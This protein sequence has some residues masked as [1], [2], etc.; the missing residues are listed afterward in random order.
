[1]KRREFTKLLAGSCSL[2]LLGAGPTLTSAAQAAPAPTELKALSRTIEVNGRAAKVFGLMQADGTHGLRLKSEDSFN[3]ALTN[4]TGEDT[5][6]H[7]HGLTPPW[8]ADGA[9]C[10]A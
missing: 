6:V 10:D 7:W 4:D 9:E 8:P 2:P 3:V 1:M 5:M